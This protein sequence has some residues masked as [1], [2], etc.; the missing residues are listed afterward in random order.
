[1]N[2]NTRAAL[3]FCLVATVVTAGLITYGLTIG[4]ESSRGG[5][6][7][8]FR[9]VDELSGFLD[10]VQSRQNSN[11]YMQDISYGSGS[12][13]KTADSASYSKTNVQVAGVDED[14]IA[15]TDGQYLFIASYDRV[16]IVRATPPSQMANVTVLEIEDLLGY[17][18]SNASAYVSGIYVYSGSLVVILSVH[19]Y[20]LWERG[21]SL[22]EFMPYIANLQRAVVSVFDLSDISS[23]QLTIS[24]G[25]SG[26]ALTSRMVQDDVY[27]VAQSYVWKSDNETYL[28]SFWNGGES[29]EF[30]ID[31]I[32]YDSDCDDTSSF[33]NLLAV[34][35][36][37]GEYEYMSMIAGY[38]STIY[39]SQSAMYLTFQKWSGELTLVDSAMAP[40]DEASTLTTIY[41]VSID[42][43]SM[44]TTARADIKGWLLNQF[45]MDEYEG[46]LR[47]ATTTSWMNPE[48]GVYVLT[49]DLE[50]AG[51][52]EN[53]APEE[54][55]YAARFLGDTLYLVTFLQ[56]DPLFVIDLSNPYL[57]RVVGELTLPG[58]SSYLHPVDE[59]HVL[60]IG[61]ENS[62]LKVSLFDVSDPTEPV[63]TSKFLA[64]NYSWS[65]ATWDHKAVL[66]DQERGMLVIPVETTVIDGM[67]YTHW[68][69]AYVFD[70]S[71]ASG[72]SLRGTI[73]HDAYSGYN[74]VLRSLYI[75]DSLYT[76]SY[77]MVKANS[78]TDLTELGS[79]TYYEPD[80]WYYPDPVPVETVDA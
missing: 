42:G 19:E 20:Q 78:I 28:P 36:G 47:V 8:T 33:I 72:I 71:A 76:V 7:S 68:S 79:L 34:D 30:S 16:S 67:N 10:E 46:Y 51:S 35:V 63:E 60:G 5:L 1:M 11:E 74:S 61:Y 12:A 75:G 9:N 38:A 24:Y 26:Y 14:D 21:D 40:E 56:I 65:M 41:K 27:L 29:E 50:S 57:P 55:I 48:N 80:W 4:K 13:E 49:P 6:L 32:F 62:R 45:S 15:K 77:S 43:L 73:S 70:V 25:V 39:M 22:A 31:R 44:V 53:I 52:L 66:F 69:G 58:F 54:R 17:E 3:A 64:E 23:P 37:D 18:L 59:T 2:S